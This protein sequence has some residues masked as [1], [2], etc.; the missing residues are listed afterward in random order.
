MS[1]RRIRY[2]GAKVTLRYKDYRSEDA[3]GKP[4]RDTIEL[5]PEEFLRR[6]VEHVPPTGFHVARSYGLLAPG[7]RDKL[8]AAR[9]QLGQLPYE[10]DDDDEDWAEIVA[11]LFPESPACCPVCGKCLITEKLIPRAQ[12]PP[13]GKIPA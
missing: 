12:S 11:A 3:N 7:H 2:D 1:D 10:P 6:V 13:G 4:K 8:N 5:E 9:T